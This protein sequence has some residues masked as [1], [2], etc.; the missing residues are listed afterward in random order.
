MSD[1]TFAELTRFLVDLGFTLH[2][3]S[4]SHH[5][6]QHTEAGANITLRLYAPE[7]RVESAGVVYVRHTL[8]QWGIMDRA[9]FDDRIQ[10]RAIAG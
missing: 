7:D 1:L 4:G 6:F 9:E 10:K 8:D 2:T 5:F 3:V